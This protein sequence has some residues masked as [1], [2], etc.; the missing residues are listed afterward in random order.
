MIE[1][2]P[3]LIESG[4]SSFKIEGR[5][6]SAYYAAVV[7]NT[8]RMAMDAYLADKENYTYDPRWLDELYSVS[9]REYCTGYFLDDCRKESHLATT[10]GYLR[11]KAYL[12]RRW[13]MIQTAFLRGSP[14]EP[15]P[16]I[17]FTSGR[18]TRS[19]SG[20]PRRF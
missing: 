20:M 12:P 13:N 17:W 2:I 9:H 4:I 1:H 16:G 7:S 14:T 18:R 6:K 11:E 15:M 3:T 8:Y 10:L 19:A 5:M